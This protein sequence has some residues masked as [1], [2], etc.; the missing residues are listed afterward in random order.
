MKAFHG[1]LFDVYSNI[2]FGPSRVMNKMKGFW[3]YFSSL[4]RD[5]E[6]AVKKI[7]KCREP[8]QYQEMV[9]RFFDTEARLAGA[10]SAP[11]EGGEKSDAVSDKA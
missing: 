6:K 2:L 10:P 4:F 7:K 1:D 9:N 11:E 3:K 5:C 8:E